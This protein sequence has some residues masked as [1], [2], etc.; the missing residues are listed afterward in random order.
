MAMTA[1][2]L[3]FGATSICASAASG[4]VASA[5]LRLTLEDAQNLAVAGSPDLKELKRTRNALAFQSAGINDDLTD[6][7]SLY[8][9]LPRYRLLYGRSTATAASPTK[10]AHAALLMQ[11]AYLSRQLA[12]LPEPKDAEQVAA[13]QMQMAQAQQ[14]MAALGLTQEEAASVITPAEQYELGIYQGYFAEIQISSPELSEAEEYEMF[15]KPLHVSVYDMGSGLHQYDLGLELAESRIRSGAADLWDGLAKVRAAATL[16]QA[17][18]SLAT[19]AASIA[20]ESFKL[21]QT[22][23]L[24]AD[25]A[26]R[27]AASARLQ[28]EQLGRQETQLVWTAARLIGMNAFSEDGT[29]ACPPDPLTVDAGAALAATMAASE[30]PAA[31]ATDAAIHVAAYA[32]GPLEDSVN[33]ALDRRYEVRTVLLDI[34]RQDNELYWM[35]TILPE[36]DAARKAAV[37]SR[38]QLDGKMAAAEAAVK[39][40]V[41]QRHLEV[42]IR[43][44]EASAAIAELSRTRQEELNVIAGGK[45][46][47]VS[48]FQLE[49][50]HMRTLQAAFACGNALRDLAQASRR[51]GESTGIGIGG[52][53]S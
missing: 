34:D 11:L 53:A 45:A 33:A 5:A 39:A 3:V 19:H 25:S 10:S 20:A 21:G 14:Q 36:K 41:A 51:L 8:G 40:D 26:G 23:R 44:Q 13:I 1:A 50:L 16:T 29:P 49:Q 2:M 37:L 24:D 15:V 7:R 18:L 42:R 9:L 27:A 52:G 4:T 12:A 38:A 28:A 31:V 48:D 47:F 30:H 46:G 35:K 17:G 32:P 6:L 22:S 43:M